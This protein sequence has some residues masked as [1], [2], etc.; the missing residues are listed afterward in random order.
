MVDLAQKEKQMSD[1]FRVGAL[2]AV[3]GGFL[4]AF[5][6]LAHGGVFANA[7]TGNIVLLGICLARG[8]WHGVF[9]YLLPIT[10]FFAG[11]GLAELV[12]RRFRYARRIH[13]RQC[14]LL[15]EVAILI[16]C[17]CAEV[18]RANTAVTVAISF[19]CALQVQSFRKVH[20]HALAT[21]MCTGNLRSA[22]EGF[23]A[24]WRDG[25]GEGYQ[26][27]RHTAGV[28]LFFMLGASSGV[29]AL[30][31]VSGHEGSALFIPATLLLLAFALLFR[32]PTSRA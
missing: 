23:L 5:T 16:G 9:R 21:T 28:V 11:I 4:D 13:W 12:R 32:T 20:G 24:W 3:V 22:I 2:L 1:S 30:R 17:A 6:F 31:L 25:K 27:A 26:R 15:A 7:Q 18:E 19:L 14:V 10:A 8:D 29:F